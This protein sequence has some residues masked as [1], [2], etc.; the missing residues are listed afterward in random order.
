MDDLF[1][2]CF[3]SKLN[4]DKS[5]ST[6]NYWFWEAIDLAS[7][8]VKEEDGLNSLNWYTIIHNVINYITEK[9][10]SLIKLD[11]G[12]NHFSAPPFSVSSNK[13][14]FK[15]GAINLAKVL[16]PEKNPIA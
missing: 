4:C 15:K 13:F 7:I 12:P 5:L 16:I 6:E 14:K 9:N 11:N 2:I 3:V 10:N 8:V 1:F